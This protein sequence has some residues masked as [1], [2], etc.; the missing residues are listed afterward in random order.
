MSKTTWTDN[1][2]GVCKHCG[3][4]N[5]HDHIDHRGERVCRNSVVYVFRVLTGD[6]RAMA[7]ACTDRLL[8]WTLAADAKLRIL[9]RTATG[10]D[11]WSH[12]Y[13][14]TAL[15]GRGTKAEYVLVMNGW[16]LKYRTT[17]EKMSTAWEF[18]QYGWRAR[19]QYVP[20]APV[21]APSRKRRVQ[22]GAPTAC[23]NCGS[24]QD[25]TFAPNPYASEVTGDNTKVYMCRDCRRAAADDV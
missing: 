12:D 19:A 20:P 25:V 24:S 21:K 18:L 4:E 9:D 11:D 3:E 23:K 8:T 5:Q 22:R 10:D 2:S 16:A 14:W 6:D 1:G 7:E 17:I 13:W 15:T